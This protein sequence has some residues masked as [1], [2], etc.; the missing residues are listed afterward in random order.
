MKNIR[1]RSSDLID[2][3]VPHLAQHEG[4]HLRGRDGQLAWLAADPGKKP[5]EAE[6]LLHPHRRRIVHEVA[7][8]LARSVGLQITALSRRQL[9]AIR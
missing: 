5:V 3:F 9:T 1:A 4:V 8:D 2:H 7:E 6:L